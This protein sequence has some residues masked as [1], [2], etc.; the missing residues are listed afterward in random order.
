MSVKIS[1]ILKEILHSLNAWHYMSVQCFP[2]SEYSVNTLN[3]NTS[4]WASLKLQT[5]IP[6]VIVI[7]STKGFCRIDVGEQSSLLEVKLPFRR[8]VVDRF[9]D[10]TKT[11]Y[12]TMI[13]EEIP[14][15]VT[16]KHTSPGLMDYETK[17]LVLGCSLQVDCSWCMDDVDHFEYARGTRTVSGNV[18]TN[19]NLF[20]FNLFF[21]L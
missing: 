17:P 19:P 11:E 10:I 12:I 1:L 3:D 5:R 6:I 14:A 20:F 13:Q 18:S 7:R 16:A 2:Q 9:D 21:L 4:S 8:P 15:M